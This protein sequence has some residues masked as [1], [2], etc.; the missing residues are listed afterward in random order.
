MSTSTVRYR[1]YL[2]GVL[3]DV[4][5]AKLS[6]PTAA[7]G[8]KRN[9]TDA[10][11][12]AD[13]TTMTKD[14]TGTYS[15]SFTDPAND[16]E[17]TA[18]VEVVFNGET[19]HVERVFDGPT[20]TTATSDVEWTA[21]SLSAQLRGELDMDPDAAGGA[22][23]DRLK[24]VVKEAGIGLWREQD[25]RFKLKLGTLTT[26][27]NQ[28]NY[29]PPTDFHEL[30]QRELNDT[31]S[32]TA[33]SMLIFTSN[34][35]VYQKY[36]DMDPDQESGTPRVAVIQQKSGSAHDWEILLT[37]PPKGVM[38]YKYWYSIWDPWASGDLSDD[39]A[40]KWPL[41][42]SHGWHLN[43]LWKAQQMFRGDER[44][45]DSKAIFEDWLAKQIRENDE[46]LTTKNL[47]PTLRGYNDFGWEYRTGD[48]TSA[49]PGI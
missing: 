4:T 18:Y 31:S 40:P 44:W 17:Y 15:Y 27:K 23:P 3:T 2:G 35:I 10:V 24:N 13:D 34:P 14:A 12:V 7:F 43:S 46:T 45:K 39:S 21:N 38:I 5:S 32:T 8:V 28:N 16:L 48:A 47:E 37:P 36:Y 22:V 26:V 11:V 9:D 25:W 1:H 20:T 6:D 41:T 42:F 29:D 19:D 33:W 30:A 49:L